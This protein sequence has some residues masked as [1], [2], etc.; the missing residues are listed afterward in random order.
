MQNV[1]LPELY[2]K[3][4]VTI[5]LNGRF[6][7]ASTALAKHDGPWHVITGW[8]PGAHRPTREQNQTANRELLARLQALGLDPVRAIGSDPD[9]DHAEESW[10][11]VGL[12]DSQAR[13]LGAEFGQI[14]VFRLAGGLQTVLACFDNWELSRTL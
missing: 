11:V 10:A 14:A 1:N 2:L 13:V 9:S 12:S 6:V 8:N 5:E 7:P 3:T 4:R